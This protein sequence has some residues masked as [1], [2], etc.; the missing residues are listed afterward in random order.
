L[1]GWGTL[2]TTAGHRDRTAAKK[3]SSD[4]LVVISSEQSCPGLSWMQ[5]QVPQMQHGACQAHASAVHVDSPHPRT[6][7]V[8]LPSVVMLAP[9]E[10]LPVE[11]SPILYS[12]PE[13]QL[14]ESS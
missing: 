6:D 11:S 7:S 14:Q 1:V 2:P 3:R 4:V 12:L 13:L 10:T 8:L 9:Q 5:K